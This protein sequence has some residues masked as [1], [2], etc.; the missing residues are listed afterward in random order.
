MLSHPNTA[1]RAS[2]WAMIV[3][4]TL[5]GGGGGMIVPAIKGFGPNWGFTDTPSWVKDG[6]A[7]DIWGATVIGY[8]YA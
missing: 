8:V 1:L 3:I 6:P 4:A 5:S 2:P 7:I